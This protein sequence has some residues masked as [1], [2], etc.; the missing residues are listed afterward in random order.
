[1]SSAIEQ[2]IHAIFVGSSKIMSLKLPMTQEEEQLVNDHIAHTRMMLGYA[3]ARAAD[4]FD[5]G[6][7]SLNS[8]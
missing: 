5:G 8:L 1:M 6:L 2:R 3:R 4:N 7:F